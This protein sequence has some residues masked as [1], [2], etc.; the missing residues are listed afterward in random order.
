MVF[1]ENFCPSF[2][3]SSHDGGLGG[4]MHW[5]NLGTMQNKGA[6]HSGFNNN[7]NNKLNKTI[8]AKASSFKASS[9]RLSLANSINNIMELLQSQFQYCLVIEASKVEG[10]STGSENQ[11]G[12]QQ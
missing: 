11:Q 10:T 7:N 2:S 1:K 6:E 3:T 9:P 8:K 4:A 12:T 5:V